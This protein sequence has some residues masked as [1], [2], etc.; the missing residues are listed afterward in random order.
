MKKCGLVQSVKGM[1][2]GL[3]LMEDYSSY[4]SLVKFAKSCRVNQNQ[5]VILNNEQGM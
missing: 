1:K 4:R 3:H 5:K 2:K